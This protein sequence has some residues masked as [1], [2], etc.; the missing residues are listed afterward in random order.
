MVGSGLKKLARQNNMKIS[1]GVAYGDLRG[2][3]AT[4]SEGAGY[5]KIAFSSYFVEAAQKDLLVQKVQTVNILETYRVLRLDIFDRSMEV[6]FHDNPGTMKKI[7]AFL[8]WFIPLLNQFEAT[9]SDICPGCG[10]QRSGGKWKLI[11]GVAHCMHES[12]AEKARLEIVEENAQ[13]KQEAT[14]SYGTGLL[15]AFLGTLLGTVVWAFLLSSGYISFL[16]GLAMGFL[17]DKGYDLFRGKQGKGKLVILITCVIL[18]VVLGTFGPDV[19]TLFTMIAEG[20]T[21]LTYSQIPVFLLELFT[22]NADYRGAVLYNGV[23][24]LFFAMMSSLMF[25]FKT[26]K[27]V[28]GEKFKDLH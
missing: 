27:A 26:A 28:G 22:Q 9:K 20:S 25:F 6:V 24:G 1:N 5:K 18:G 15:G 4:L 19:F 11:N 7:V 21:D 17:A 13:K 10:M 8:D 3:A 23:M 14:G 2:Y 16:G 12:C